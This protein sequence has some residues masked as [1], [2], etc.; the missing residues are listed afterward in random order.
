MTPHL[1]ASFERFESL[2][3]VIPARSTPKYACSAVSLVLASRK[4]LHVEEHLVLHT[5]LI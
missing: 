5:Y 2:H 3:S 4:A 1:I